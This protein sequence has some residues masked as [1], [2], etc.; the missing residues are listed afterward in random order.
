[1]EKF[2]KFCGTQLNELGVCTSVH[3]A[4]RKMCVNCSFVSLTDDGYLCNNK[5]NMEN[6]RKKI[7]EAANSAAS[8][9]G[10]Y[11][12]DNF[13]FDIKPLPLKRPTVKCTLWELNNDIVDE[14]IKSFE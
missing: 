10:G 1:M 12:I 11:S 8:A 9:A 14:F 6:T 7:I 3:N 4:N 2:C 5:V 13:N